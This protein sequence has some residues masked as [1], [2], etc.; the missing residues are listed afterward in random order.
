MNRG[1]LAWT[2]NPRFV[3]GLL[4]V[5]GIGTGIW[6]LIESTFRSM[7]TKTMFPFN[8]D[9]AN[10]SSTRG[11]FLF[12]FLLPVGLSGTPVLR[13][14]LRLLEVSPC[15]SLTL[16]GVWGWIWAPNWPKV[17]GAAQGFEP[18]TT[19]S[20]L[21]QFD[22]QSSHCALN[23]DTPS[24]KGD[25]RATRVFFIFFIHF[26]STVVVWLRSRHGRSNCWLAQYVDNPA[27]LRL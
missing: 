10:T 11:G 7:T 8:S 3:L 1:F 6:T 14:Q 18:R 25:K 26:S 12:F 17:G 21:D 13:P 19:N 24:F 23:V 16:G 22:P 15:H 20:K 4:F 27:R 5:V 9:R 2:E